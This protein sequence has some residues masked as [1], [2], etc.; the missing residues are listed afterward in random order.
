[1]KVLY[2]SITPFTFDDDK[3]G[4]KGASWIASL[5]RIMSSVKDVQI[6]VSYVNLNNGDKAIQHR[7]NI[8]IYPI[9]IHRNKFQTFKDHTKL[10]YFDEIVVRKSLKVI[11]GYKPDII[12]I[13]GSEWNF[14]LITP[15]T[16]VPVVIHMQ[17]FWP[18]YRN[19]NLLKSEFALKTLKVLP[20]TPR[21]LFSNYRFSSMSKQRA[22]REEKILQMNKYF[23]GRTEWDK[24]IIY[25]YNSH[26][27]YF[28]VNEALRSEF[29]ESKQV[30]HLHD[31]TVIKL[32]SVGT[33]EMKGID[34]ILKTALL[35]KEN[36]HGNFEWIIFGKIPRIMD[37]KTITN[38]EA[39]DV[40]IHFVGN[41]TAEDILSTL[42]DADMYVHAAYAENSPNSICEAQMIGLPIVTSYA[43][44]IVS[45]F[46]KQ[47]DASMFTPINDP[48]YLASKIIQ[49]IKDKALCIKL[50]KLNWNISRLRNSDEN[51]LKETLN[52][53]NT[54]ISCHKSSK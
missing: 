2:F 44:G 35:L 15:F 17:G 42:L 33:S 24:S 36:C 18:Q 50:S 1:M 28:H 40:N 49:L 19:V 27:R 41:G 48:F 31:R 53:Y 3:V 26:A 43:G 16:D 34:V 30:W 21:Q 29:V 37:L 7:D 32:V 5:I 54:I 39:Q 46:D 47:Y 38:I 10:A 6:A 4:I 51:I 45:L 13:F 52:A 22:E 23:F 11:E 20:K 14:G 12:H 25:L 9:N 8:S